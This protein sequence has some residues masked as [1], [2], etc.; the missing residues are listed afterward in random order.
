MKKIKIKKVNIDAFIAA[1]DNCKGNVWLTTD[2]GDKY[3]LRSKLSQ[4]VGL[5][6]ILKGADIVDAEL[7]IENE[8]DAPILLT[9]LMYG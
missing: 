1:L 4:L 8:E 7:L 9:H 6:S 2:E 3:N 5:S